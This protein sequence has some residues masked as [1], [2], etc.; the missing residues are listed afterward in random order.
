MSRTDAVVNSIATVGLYSAIP[1]TVLMQNVIAGRTLLIMLVTVLP[2][3]VPTWTTVN[4]I[5][6]RWID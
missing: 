3:M 4:H 2:R 5:Q 1:Q 6:D